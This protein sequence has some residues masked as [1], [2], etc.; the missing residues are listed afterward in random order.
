MRENKNNRTWL[1]K[2]KKENVNV[3]FQNLISCFMIYRCRRNDRTLHVGNDK[4]LSKVQCKIEKVY[5]TL[6]VYRTITI[7]MY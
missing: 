5:S 6:E 7:L 2:I 1:Y 4:D 3:V